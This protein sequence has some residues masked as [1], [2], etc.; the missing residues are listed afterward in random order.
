[1]T[2]AHRSQAL[3]QSVDFVATPGGIAVP[4]PKG[5][6][7]RVADNGKGI[8]YQRH[9]AMGNA[10]TIRIMEPT[11]RYPQGYVRYYNNREQPLD[12][13]GR[14]GDRASTHIPLD[15]KGPISGWPR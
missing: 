7:G 5:W 15:Y 6:I 4:I 1:M 9:G 14:P 8:V 12:P 2:T 10:D 3:V 11:P 13:A